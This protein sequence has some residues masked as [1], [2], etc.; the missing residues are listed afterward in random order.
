MANFGELGPLDQAILLAILRLQPKAYGISIQDEIKVSAKR[1]YSIG[2]IYAALDRLEDRGYVS[3]ERGEATDQRGGRAKRYFSVTA[4][5]QATL[6]AS[7]QGIA[8]LG[9]ARL[10]GAF[11]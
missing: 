3:G 2:A 10:I 9:G 5:G 8:S 7:L 6:K 4:P 11:A 1:E